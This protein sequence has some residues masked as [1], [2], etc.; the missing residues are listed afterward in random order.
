MSLNL[1]FSDHLFNLPVVLLKQELDMAESS[2]NSYCRFHG[3]ISVENF[4]VAFQIASR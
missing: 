4:G 1:W 3:L 2:T